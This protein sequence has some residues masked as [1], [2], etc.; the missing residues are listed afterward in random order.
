MNNQCCM[1]VQFCKVSFDVFIKMLQLIRE[2]LLI[3]WF[4]HHIFIQQPD[5]K[6]KNKIQFNSINE[7]DPS[8]DFSITFMNF[9]LTHIMKRKNIFKSSMINITSKKLIFLIKKS[10]HLRPGFILSKS[11]VVVSKLEKKKKKYSFSFF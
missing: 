10:I 7:N 3:C 5:R 9:K 11:F 4:V 2:N 6:T 1:Q 8:N